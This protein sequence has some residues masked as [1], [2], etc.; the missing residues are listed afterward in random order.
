MSLIK[1]LLVV[2]Y[3]VIRGCLL[4]TKSFGEIEDSY[5]VV[6]WF[7]AP[8]PTSLEY[9]YYLNGVACFYEVG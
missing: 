5:K 1:D 7:F 3:V 4:K 2:V 9:T 8:S 6:K